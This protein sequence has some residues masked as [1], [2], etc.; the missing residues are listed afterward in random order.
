MAKQRLEPDIWLEDSALF[1]SDRQP[2]KALRRW[3]ED[4]L[5]RMQQTV[6][7]LKELGALVRG[8]PA[9]DAVVAVAEVHEVGS[10]WALVDYDASSVP[11]AECAGDPLMS[12]RRQRCSEQIRAQTVGETGDLCLQMLDAMVRGN[13]SSLHWSAGKRKLLVVGAA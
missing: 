1:L 10:D 2:D 9:L 12:E 4:H 8:S 11:V 5:P 6:E 7:F 3:F 13:S